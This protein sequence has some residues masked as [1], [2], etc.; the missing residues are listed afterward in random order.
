[1]TH[2]V[3]VARCVLQVA[4]SRVAQRA[5]GSEASICAVVGI[6]VVNP[7]IA[8]LLDAIQAPEAD[9]RPSLYNASCPPCC[10]LIPARNLAS[11]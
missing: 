1:M 4:M 6:A 10:I 7:D 2:D 5:L 8:Q 3:A 11:P 9:Q